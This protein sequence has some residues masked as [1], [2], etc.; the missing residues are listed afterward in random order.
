MKNKIL[1][2]EPVSKNKPRINEFKDISPMVARAFLQR[3]AMII[4]GEL[5]TL[6]YTRSRHPDY[7]D[8]YPHDFDSEF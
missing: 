4:K 7:M 5:S 2:K 3:E 8:D 6:T 1:K